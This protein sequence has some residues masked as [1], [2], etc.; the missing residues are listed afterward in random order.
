MFCWTDFDAHAA[1]VELQTPHFLLSVSD[2]LRFS[3]VQRHICICSLCMLESMH[4][5]SMDGV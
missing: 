2:P 5:K 4:E 3:L 1:N